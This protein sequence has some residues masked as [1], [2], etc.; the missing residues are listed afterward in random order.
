MLIP[1]GK[2][3]PN[4]PGYSES[5]ALLWEDQE[6][7]C[8]TDPGSDLADADTWWYKERPNGQKAE[9]SDEVKFAV[10]NLLT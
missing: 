1:P 6:L 3:D 10:G 9:F 2:L 7:E 8:M 4:Q 5:K